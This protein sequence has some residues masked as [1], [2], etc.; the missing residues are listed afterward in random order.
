M[1]VRVLAFVAIISAFAAAAPLAAPA[2]ARAAGQ[3]VAIIVGPA[4]SVTD[5][6]IGYADTTAAAATAAG[7]TVVK[8]YSPNAS[9]ANVLAAVAGA[10]I[11]V[12]YGHGNG[13]PNPYSTTVDPN[14]VNGWG[15]QGPGAKGTHEDSWSN[16][17]LKYYG[18][19][20]IAANARPAPGFVM[21]YA[22]ACYAPGASE[23]WDTPATEDVAKARVNYYS[24]GVLGMGA[25]A[26]FATDFYR[27]AATLVTKILTA[28]TM[29]FGDIFKSEPKFVASALRTFYH[30]HVGGREVWVHRSANYAG[31]VNYWYAFAG[32]PRATPSGGAATP[33]PAP[34]PADTTAPVVAASSPANAGINVAAAANVWVWFSEPV[35]GVGAATM[36]LR[37][38]TTGAVIATTIWYDAASNAAM[39]RPA[40]PLGAGRTY[41]VAMSGGIR[42]Y[43]GNALSSPGFSFTVAPGETLPFYGIRFLAGTHTGYIFDA[44]G[45]VW[46]SKTVSLGSTQHALTV[47]RATIT[48][49][50]GFWLYVVD[51]PFAGYWF[52]EWPYSYV[53]GF[54]G[55]TN[56]AAPRPVTFEAATHSG[57]VFD[58]YANNISWRTLAQPAPVV[59]TA[60]ARAIINGRAYLHMIDGPYAYH[61]VV[62]SSVVRLG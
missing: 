59:G 57:Y 34:L 22:N 7:A 10:N 5:T 29:A 51:G 3:R 16:G 6:Y 55:Y 15:L 18:E 54:V 37:D 30:E 23:G 58:W 40:A 32:D 4:G 52:P 27:G 20:W 43:A 35:T 14:S 28:P 8:A 60:N 45:A 38:T 46:T 19:A 25:G 17:T 39:L 61:W 49:Q 53:P 21:I 48:G 44:N 13:F 2:P 26:Y 12:Y 47:H 41:H 56:F 9:A 62:E 31:E 42:D 1:R 24:R 50:H 36:A 33:A 11:I